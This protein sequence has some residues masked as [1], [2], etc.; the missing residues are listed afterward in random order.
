MSLGIAAELQ[1][2]IFNALNGNLGTAQVYANG[3]APDNL[4][5]VYVTIGNDTHVE[6]DNDTSLGFESTITLHAFDKTGQRGFV[7][8]K[9][10]MGECYNLLHRANI[11][12]NGFKLLG[13]DQEFED[14]FIDSDGLTPHG[15]LRYRV[16]TETI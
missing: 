16:I 15:V 12:V 2:A 7:N 13:I 8:L 10:L 6:F 9:P 4:Q 5:A 1:I 14:A 3:N 11:A